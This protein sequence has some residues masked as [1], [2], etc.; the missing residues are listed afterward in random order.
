GTDGRPVLLLGSP[1]SSRLQF[2]SIGG[3]GGVRL[4][5]D[6]VDVFAEFEFR[7]LE[8]VFRPDE[9]DGFIAAVVPSEGFS[10]SADLAV[11]ISHKLGIYFRGASRLEIQLPVRQSIGP[12][13]IQGLSVS[14]LPSGG[15]LPVALGASFTARLGPVTAMVDRIGLKALFAGRPEHDGNLGPIDVSLGFKPPTGLGLSIDAGPVT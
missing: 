10:V 4:V 5:G 11:G 14:V 13:E 7:G 8:F 12:V 9:A 1:D 6:D 2:R 3:T 15:M